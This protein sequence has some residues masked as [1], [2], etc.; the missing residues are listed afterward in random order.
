ME[1]LMELSLDGTQ[2]TDVAAL[3][4]LSH[5]RWLGVSDTKI[6][7]TQLNALHEALPHCQIRR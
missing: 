6:G 5:L 4:G 1:N 7:D 2:V 3:H